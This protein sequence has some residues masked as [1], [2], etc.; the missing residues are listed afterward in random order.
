MDEIERII[1]YIFMKKQKITLISIFYG[2]MISLP[3]VAEDIEIYKSSSTSTSS[4]QANI[5]FVLDTSGSMDTLVTTRE[6]YNPATDYSGGSACY[7][8]DRVYAMSDD[9]SFLY[10]W[11]W[12]ETEAERLC[13]NAGSFDYYVREVNRTAVVCD[14]ASALDSTGTFSG[15]I[16]Q[17]RS[18]NWNGTLARN[19]LTAYIE[20]ELDSGVHGQNTGNASRYASKNTPPAWSSSSS[21]EI[22]WGS[23]GSS[24]TLHSGNYLNYVINATATSRMRIDI[25]KSVMTDMVNSVSGINIGLMRFSRSGS[26]GMVVTPVADIGPVGADGVG[27]QRHNFLDE[28]NRMTP[29]GNTPLSESFYEAVMYFQGKAVD[30]GLASTEESGSYPSVSSSRS[31]GNYIS[32]INNECQKN[33]IVLLTDGDPVSD[34]LNS[35]RKNNIDSG[36]SVTAV[37]GSSCGGSSNNCLDEIAKSIGLNDQRSTLTGDQV[38]STFTIGFSNSNALLQDTADE[39]KAATED[40][41]RFYADDE[42]SLAD[43]LNTIFTSVF[44]T[45]TTFSSPAVSV[46][47]FNRS[48]HLNDLYF[49]LFKPGI[50]AHW[51]GNLKKYELDFFTDSDGVRQPFIKD[52]NGNN[53]VDGTGFFKDTDPKALSFWSAS[54]DGA[55]VAEGGVAAEF[56]YTTSRNVYTYTSTYTNANGV[57]KPDSS[58]DLTLSANEVDKANTAITS[59]VAMLDI[60]TLP[61]KISGT[62]RRDTLL[63]WAA[64]LDVFDL[65]GAT[66]TTT[67][68]RME[69]GDPLHSQ[70]ALVQYGGTIASPD[71]VA[72]VATNDGYLHAIDTDDGSEIFAFIPQELLSNLNTVMDNDTGEKTYGLDGDVIAWINDENADG[73]ISGAGEHVY[74]YVGMRRGGKNIYSIDVTD[75]T[76]PKLRWVIKGGIGDYADLGQ[77][78]STVNIEKIKDGGTEKTVLI[79]GGGY[80]TNQDGVSV[81]STDSIGQAVFI[82]DADSGKL[83]WKGGPSGNTVVPEMN[84]S[85]PA[86][87]KPLDLSGDGLI[88]RMYVADTG[89]QIFRFDID[90]KSGAALSSSI[91]GGRIADLAKD[92]DITAARRFYYPPD[93]ALIAERGKSAYLALAIASGYR[94]HPNNTDIRDRIYL[95]KDNDVYN[96]P[97]SYVTL[98]EHDLYNATE[99]LAGDE[100]VSGTDRTLQESALS[101]LASKDGWYI[102]LDDESA[103]GNWVG[104]KGLSEALI[105]EGQV[106]VTTFVPTDSSGATVS[107]SPQSGKGKVFFMGVTDATPVPAADVGDRSGRHPF[108]IKKEGIPPTV[109]TNLPDGGEATLCIGTECKAADMLRGVRRTFWNEVEK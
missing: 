2:M 19:D 95:L 37:S 70:P 39:S 40:G 26:G 31:G 9:F 46:N 50:G 5:L 55:T 102:Y 71:L 103:A 13:N 3:A 52:A 69:M 32:P 72:F 24:K 25:M 14:A 33:F 89:G 18:D 92:S 76:K 59:D 8:P 60:A 67:D 4:A 108:D 45:N 77:T 88:D 94:A 48:V 64:G 65:Y 109:T 85:I 34:S 75:R 27:T 16:A 28:L 78:W 29:R 15:N 20:C 53:A 97:S 63:D 73:T 66:G 62:P 35:D 106:I 104:E 54:V 81:R 30:Y 42:L 10:E 105:L 51:T 49:T 7:N 87:I 43:S 1:M 86:R 6:A 23:I 22:N 36:K 44:K 41:Q 91:K 93:V 99:N 101:A 17:Y 47:A 84:Y 11:W 38:I 58:A 74:L 61:E 100:G 57:F 68:M 96:T 82:A 80:D 79:F 98:T 90:N 21:D 107:C 56:K 83:L 12:G